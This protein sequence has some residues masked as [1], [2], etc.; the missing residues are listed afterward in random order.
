MLPG[1]VAVL[2]NASILFASQVELG[3]RGEGCPGRPQRAEV[4]PNR[5]RPPFLP[6]RDFLTIRVVLGRDGGV[7]VSALCAASPRKA[8]RSVGFGVIRSGLQVLLV[9]ASRAC[10]T[11]ASTPACCRFFREAPPAAAFHVPGLLLLCFPTAP[12]ATRCRFVYLLVTDCR[13]LVIKAG[14]FSVS[15]PALSQVL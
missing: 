15:F 1:A 11:A 4:G 6:R 9:A 3:M 10:R 5:R 8:G 14:A 12:D 2:S 13:V 7:V